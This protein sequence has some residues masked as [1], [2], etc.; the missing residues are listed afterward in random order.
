MSE[1]EKPVQQPQGPQAD[2]DVSAP[3]KK[4]KN[5]EPVLPDPP[6]ERK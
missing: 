4:S 6:E 2:V 3:V 5:A 1:K